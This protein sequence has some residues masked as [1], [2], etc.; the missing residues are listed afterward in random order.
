MAVTAAGASKG[1]AGSGGGGR[2]TLHHFFAKKPPAVA[3]ACTAAA[4]SQRR[5]EPTGPNGTSRVG[6]KIPTAPPTPPTPAPQPWLLQRG[7]PPTPPSRPMSPRTPP[8]PPQNSEVG[9]G[10]STGGGDDRWPNS[11]AKNSTDNNNGN[12]G[13]IGSETC[14]PQQTTA[15]G[16]RSNAPSDQAKKSQQQRKERKTAPIFVTPVPSTSTAKAAKK[17]SA[18]DAAAA[19]VTRPAAADDEQDTSKETIMVAANRIGRKRPPLAPLFASPRSSADGLAMMTVTPSS[20]VVASATASTSASNGR[21]RPR[22]AINDS[23]ITRPS[24]STNATNNGT[25][26]SRSNSTIS[27]SSA[28]TQLY[29][30]LGQSNFAAR[31]ICPICGMMSVHGMAEDDAEH[32]RICSEYRKGIAFAGWKSERVVG[33]FGDSGGGGAGLK[34]SIGLGLGM[35]MGVGMGIANKQGKDKSRVS[36]STSGRIVEVRPTDPVQHRKL[37]RPVKAIVDQELGFADSSTSAK[38]SSSVASGDFDFA[39]DAEDDD[40]S[41]LFG[42]TAYLYVSN[43]AVVGFCTVEVIRSAHRLLDATPASDGQSSG[44]SEGSRNDMSDLH[45]STKPTKA[46]MGVHQ[47]WCHSSHRKGKVATRLVDAARSQLVYGMSVPHGMVAF[48]SPTV[49]GLTFAKRYVQTE[50]PLIYDCH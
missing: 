48:S 20:C 6:S 11:S 49:A 32:E 16:N 40:E 33:T 17:A 10:G 1:T 44:G 31:S 29:L 30:D 21:K 14:T 4:S 39:Q 50:T 24:T 3:A 5:V 25:V 12:N 37:V 46:I 15:S 42:R 38:R 18:V 23:S 13:G 7:T 41:S 26:F 2:Q 36:A 22:S 35:S 43:K 45:R 34:S 8:S 9:A 28:T 19:A 47:L 27:S